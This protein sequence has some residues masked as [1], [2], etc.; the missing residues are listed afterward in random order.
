MN[1]PKTRKWRDVKRVFREYGIEAV[2]QS[3]S[4]HRRPRHALLVG[5]GGQ[6]FPIPARRESDDIS[7]H[8]VDAARRKFGLTPDR[9]VSNRDFW[10]RF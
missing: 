10:G 4:G 9:G 7:R 5:P 8:Y 2:E 6:K 3:S 1:L